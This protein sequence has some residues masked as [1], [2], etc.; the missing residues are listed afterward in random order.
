MLLPII[1]LLPEGKLNLGFTTLNFITAD[2]VLHP[3]IQEK[4]DISEIVALADTTG[5]DEVE[6]ITEDIEQVDPEVVKKNLI[7]NNN[8]KLLKNRV[9]ND[10]KPTSKNSKGVVKT[11]EDIDA[12]LHLTDLARQNLFAFFDKMEQVAEKKTKVHILHYGDSQ[13]EGDRMTGFIRQ[14]IQNQFGGNG[15]G[16]IP[17]MNVYV[18][19]SYKQSYSSNFY[20]YT[21]FGGEKISSKKYGVMGAVAKFKSDSTSSQAWIEIEPSNKAQSRSRYYNQVKMFYTEC[22]SKCKVKVYYNDQLILDDSLKSDGQ[23][24]VLP[25]QFTDRVGKLKYVFEGKESPVFCGFSLEGEYGVQVDNIGMR[26]C[27]GT[28]FTGIE[29]STL[30]NMMSDLNAELILLQF[31]G[32]SVPYFKDSA[33]V[34]R[35]AKFF[36]SQ[37]K[38]IKQLNPSAAIIVIGPSDM[39]K[40]S[41]GIYETYDF[42]PYCVAQM[43]KAA[44]NEGA[45][46][47]DLYKAM[48]GK[49]SMPAW[50]ESGLAG[51]DYIHFTNKGASIASQLF[52][53]ALELELSKWKDQK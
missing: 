37:I 33:S 3:K 31:G 45:G 12:T 9:K 23:Y 38:T 52:Y 30:K 25:L 1:F 28:F 20:R 15:P 26:G 11:I 41:D 32:N 27:S 8:S 47:W 16:L 48:G 50:V 19:N 22:K 49:N 10:S 40:M 21:C 24:H 5:L 17:A 2:E 29:K 44:A 51:R 14:R 7:L 13:I 34:R 43:K 39:S 46:Y 6:E 53:D 4:K 36:Q 18:T 35:Y 42:L